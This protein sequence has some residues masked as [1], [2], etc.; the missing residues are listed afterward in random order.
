VPDIRPL[1]NADVEPAGA[2]LGRAFADNPA[3]RAIFRH[4]PDERRAKVVGRVKRGFTAAAVSWQEAHG[5][6]EGG[7]L[8]G[9][10]LVCAP[11]Q[12]PHGFLAFQRHAAGCLTAGWRG[13]RNL[14]LADG[15]IRRRHIRGPH[16]YLFVLGIDPSHQ[17]RGLGRA[18]LGALSE[19]ADAASLPCY[20]ETDKPSSVELYRSAGYAVLTEEDVPRIPGMHMWT[21]CR[22]AK[23]A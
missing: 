8:A 19:R 4:L 9:A 12:Y 18:L 10:S 5:I 20:L 15:Y 6:W 1:A 3:Y 7:T 11:G 21:M 23:G 2:L 14:L 17:K 16:Y 13:I 22:P